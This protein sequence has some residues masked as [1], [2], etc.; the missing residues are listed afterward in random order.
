MMFINS[1]SPN[2][3]REV[4]AMPVLAMCNFIPDTDALKVFALE[5]GFS[6]I[7]WSFDLETLPKTP[8]E[9]SHWVAQMSTLQP[10]LVRYHCPFEKID[11]GH[12]NPE[13][14][15]M[16][17]TLYRRIVRLIAKAGGKM[18]TIHIGLGRDSTQPMSW[19]ETIRNLSRLVQYGGEHG[20]K[21]CLENLAWGWTSKPNLFEK[22]VRKSGAG[23]TLDIGHA[24]VSEAVASQ[25]FSVADF[26]SPHSDRVYNAH[27]YHKELDDIGHIPP[28]RID[29]VSERLDILREIGCAWWVLEIKEIAGLMQTK[30]IIDDYLEKSLS[31]RDAETEKTSSILEGN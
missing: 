6:G 12:E 9:E 28:A 31:L 27:V 17:E 19:D 7:D 22:L 26:I 20:I 13:H 8:S 15:K 10:L 1:E 14:V 24:Y 3:K 29:D 5:N 16:A 4:A 23:V 11:L 30:R 2:G 25:Q 18:V 21:V